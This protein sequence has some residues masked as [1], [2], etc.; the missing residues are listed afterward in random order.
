VYPDFNDQKP[1]ID[2][3]FAGRDRGSISPQ[4]LES[5]YFVVKGAKT[6]RAERE[7]RDK[8]RMVATA[9]PTPRVEATDGKR[10]LNADEKVLA[11][12]FYPNLPETEAVKKYARFADAEPFEV[13]VPL[14]NK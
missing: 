10:A 3:I 5:A 9:P 11:K 14:G 1:D 2:K 8:A 6:A 13:N 4:E 7:V 12:K